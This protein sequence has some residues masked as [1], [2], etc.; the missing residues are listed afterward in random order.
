[1]SVQF[2]RRIFTTE[3]KRIFNEKIQL[4]VR[5]L[6]FYR[7]NFPPYPNFYTDVARTSLTVMVEKITKIMLESHREDTFKLA[8]DDPFLTCYFDGKLTSLGLKSSTRFPSPIALVLDKVPY[9]TP[10]RE[11]GPDQC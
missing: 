10:P 5:V 4:N 11:E 3:E 6:N 7:Q 2:Q 9:E 1:M 8:K